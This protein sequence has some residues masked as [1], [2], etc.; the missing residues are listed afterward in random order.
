M[1]VLMLR[2]NAFEPEERIFKEARTLIKAGHDV[3]LICWD[4][5]LNFPKKEN[6]DG[7][8]IERI[9]LKCGFG[10]PVEMFFKLQKFW[11]EIYKKSKSLK[12]DVVHAFDYDTLPIASRIKKER[13]CK[14]IYNALELFLG[15]TSN[16]IINQ[17]LFII[18][19]NNLKYVDVLIHAN[20]ER[21]EI[22][23]K[24]TKW[25]KKYII[26]H[27]YPPLGIKKFKK[28]YDKIIFQYCGGIK[29]D[30]NIF[31]IVKAFSQIKNENIEF[32]I[33]GHT[34]ND[35][36]R[37]IK[38]FI[39]KN[40]IKNIII[41]DYIPFTELLNFMRKTHVGFVPVAKTSLNNIIPE[42]TKL[43]DNFATGNISIVENVSYLKKIINKDKL[44][45]YCDFS[46]I[47]DIKKNIQKI[48]ETPKK[49]LKIKAE[50]CYNKY[51]QE[52]NWKHEEEK[53]IK[54]YENLE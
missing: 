30:R 51:L 23:R 3:K 26:L 37:K 25:N 49:E 8:E 6:Y 16:K 24:K 46:N 19:K 20:E 43:Y 4:R 50:K 12:F 21:F 53:L 54:V 48:I 11:N 34:N 2:S 35:Y 33:Y 47:N 7:I 14:L 9:R 1:K 52:Y 39:G 36:G 17:V 44:G 5:Q 42:P 45:F 13:N 15:Y 41:K 22:F 38:E 32:Y 18:E 40:R 10:N 29:K 31:N 28:D 27:N